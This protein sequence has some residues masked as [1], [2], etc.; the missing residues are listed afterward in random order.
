MWVFIKKMPCFHK[1]CQDE[2]KGV[3][4]CLVDPG[5]QKILLGLERFGKYRGKFNLC[6]GS[7]EPEDGGCAVEAAK[8]E[9]REEFKVVFSPQEF[10][11]QFFF[12]EQTVLRVIMV[13]ATP[14][15]IGYVDLSR[16]DTMELGRRMMTAIQDDTLPGTHKEMEQAQWF[17]WED[18]A[19]NT[20][21][22]RFARVAMKKV[23]SRSAHH[24]LSTFNKAF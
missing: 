17:P 20:A 19:S 11:R 15:L 24:P 22:S 23:L 18:H 4:V 9:L 13:G 21:W 12:R 10:Q 1:I 6:A 16:L 7:L 2:P 8:R 14:V 3:A 5:Q